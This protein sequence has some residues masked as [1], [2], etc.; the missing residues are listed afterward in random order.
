MLQA[1]GAELHKYSAEVTVHLKS[2]V[3]ESKAVETSSNQHLDAVMQ[4]VCEM[5]A[6]ALDH[7]GKARDVIA[8][9][10]ATSSAQLEGIKQASGLNGQEVGST[11]S[12]CEAAVK[13]RMASLQHQVAMS[14]EALT[15]WSAAAFSK[16]H[17]TSSQLSKML[18]EHLGATEADK[19]SSEAHLTE[20]AGILSVQRASLDAMAA[21]LTAQ[22][23]LQLEMSEALTKMAQECV[24]TSS[25]HVESARRYAEE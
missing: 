4:A 7:S 1:L 12:A 18:E 11:V 17:D 20:T 9:G 6:A 23:A 19:T 10:V 22:R 25:A 16:L 5:Q 3:E 2:V 8:E 13:T 15:K 14:E 21:D 24:A